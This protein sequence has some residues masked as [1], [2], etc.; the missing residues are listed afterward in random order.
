[1]AYVAKDDIIAFIDGESNFIQGNSQTY[2]IILYKDFIGSVL[3]LNQPTS[4]NVAVYVEDKKVLQFSRPSVSGVSVDLDVDLVDNTGKISFN[5]N[6]TNSTHL[7]AGRLYAQV[8]VYYENYYPQPKNYVF[9]RLLLG[10]VINNPNI[11]NG[12]PS[13]ETGGGT[14]T[15]IERGPIEAEFQVE[16]IDGSDPSDSGMVSMSSANP[17]L[18]DFIIFRNLDK[19]GIRISGLENFLTKR[20]SGDNINGIITINDIAETN[21]YAI[22]RVDSWERL[23]LNVGG[24]DADNLDGI[25]VNV[26]L[27]TVSTGPGVTQTT[28]QVGQSVSYSMDAHGITSTSVL[29]D[30]GILT[31]V[32]KNINPSAS[33]GNYSATGILITY[34]PYQDSY[35]MVE[36]N[37]LSVEVGDGTKDKDAY[38]SGN[39]GSTAASVEEIRSGD[40]LYWNGDIAGYELEIGDEI[41]LIYEAKSDDLR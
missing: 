13:G 31:Y 2:D 29:P 30:D 11:D 8:S 25:K 34:S 15:I 14:T 41:N 17:A 38:F 10:D 23:D 27:E 28:W 37:G 40:Q 39:N 9:P 36:V 21:M 3:N 5:I 35:V 24:G 12:D 6:E 7:S 26:S 20:I 18:V 32:D 1:M 22:Y 4:F 33:V 19:N 16:H